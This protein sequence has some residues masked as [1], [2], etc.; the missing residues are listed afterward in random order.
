MNRG[1]ARNRSRKNSS[2]KSC[3]SCLSCLPVGRERNHR[4]IWRRRR[5]PRRRQPTPV[6]AVCSLNHDDLS[7]PSPSRLRRADEHQLAAQRH[8]RGQGQTRTLHPSVATTAQ[9]APCNGAHSKHGIFQPHRRRH[10]RSGSPSSA[11]VGPCPP[12]RSFR[13]GNRRLSQRVESHSRRSR[14]SSNHARF[15]A[16]P[17]PA[18]P[19]RQR[20]CRPVQEGGQRSH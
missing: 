10:R 12:E 9:G 11:G 13:A 2:S 14:E 16:P 7:Q 1:K 3:S 8:C 5:T 17:S 6:I 4:Q 19:G 15:D 20:R 18:L